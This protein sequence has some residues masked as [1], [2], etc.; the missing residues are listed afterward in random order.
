MSSLFLRLKVSILTV[1]LKLLYGSGRWQVSGLNNF[2]NLRKKQKSF[3]IAFWHGNLLIPCLYLAKYQFHILAGFHR[4]AELAVK[5]GKKIGWKFLRG[6]SSQSGSEVFQEIVELLS[7]PNKVLAITPDGPKG[8]AKIPKP[9][10]VRAAQKTSVPILPAAACSR[11]SWG[12]TNWDT[13][14]VTK[15]FTRIELTFGKP[16]NFR[17]D[18]N[19]DNCLNKLKSELDRLEKVVLNNINSK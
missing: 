11:R 8:P 4:D 18:D 16:L 10:A 9:G 5:I 12:F 2:E 6:S 14:H 17:I 19:F 3:I 13:F 15:P 7:R 1:L